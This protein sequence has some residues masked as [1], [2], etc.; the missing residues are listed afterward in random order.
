MSQTL[1]CLMSLA[2]TRESNATKS[3]RMKFWNDCISVVDQQLVK[4]R[5][6]YAP[7]MFRSRIQAAFT[8][9]LGPHSMYMYAAIIILQSAG[10]C[11]SYINV[12]HIANDWQAIFMLPGDIF[13]H[14]QVNRTIYQSFRR[15]VYRPIYRL[16]GPLLYGSSVKGLHHSCMLATRHCS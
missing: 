4:Q 13:S 11:N 3:I 5:M 6:L 1:S 10:C 12:R 9:S 8:L 7:L 15:P 2:L 14:P 16:V